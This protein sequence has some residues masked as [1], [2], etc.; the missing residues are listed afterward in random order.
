AGPQVAIDRVTPNTL[1]ISGGELDVVLSGSSGQPLFSLSGQ[2]AN[3][4]PLETLADGRV[5]YRLQAPS[6]LPGPASL[7]V[8]AGNGSRASMVG[9]VQFVEPLLLR[10]LDPAQGSFNG[11]S[12]VQI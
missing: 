6:S 9:A 11:G 3:A 4:V 12:R 10:S 7:Q 5:R 2:V 8:V 1:E